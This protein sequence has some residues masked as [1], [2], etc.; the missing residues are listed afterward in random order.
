M[1]MQFVTALMTKSLRKSLTLARSTIVP[2]SEGVFP[3]CLRPYFSNNEHGPIATVSSSTTPSIFGGVAKR[4][5]F[6][7]DGHRLYAPQASVHFQPPYPDSFLSGVYQSM[8]LDWGAFKSYQD[9]QGPSPEISLSRSPYGEGA[10]DGKAAYGFFFG[11]KF[12]YRPGIWVKDPW[13]KNLE[14]T[15]FSATTRQEML[16]LQHERYV[17]PPLVYDYPGDAVSR[18]LDSMT[19]EDYQ[20]RTFGVSRDTIRLL[21]TSETSG[22]FGLGPDVLSAFLIYEW[23]KDNSDGR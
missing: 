7:V 12:G 23:N 13:G 5:E 15:P 11:A 18:Q 1:L 14:G 10:I 19:I 17:A 9:W 3:A 22:G 4:N 6:L 8:G 16:A 21:T 2:S 20:V